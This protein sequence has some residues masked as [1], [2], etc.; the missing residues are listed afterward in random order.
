LKDF[1]IEEDENEDKSSFSLLACECKHS[2]DWQYMTYIY[3]L[4]VKLT[5]K[6]F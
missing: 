4:C 5:I 6:Y 1:H 3:I 2:N